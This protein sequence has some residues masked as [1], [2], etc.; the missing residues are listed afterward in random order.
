MASF[1]DRHG[2]EWH[3]EITP[4]SMKRVRELTAVN[5]GTLFNDNMTP[6]ANLVSDPIMFVDVLYV[7]CKP[8]CD[9]LG[10]T[11]EQF[12]G[13]MVGDYLEAAVDAFM[14]GLVD[15]FPKRQSNLLSTLLEK[16]RQY[17]AALAEKAVAQLNQ[18]DVTSIGSAMNLQP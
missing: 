15:F 11:D 8:E 13:A 3:F 6:L 12:G 9:K 14:Q 16:N 5:L 10:V 7:L 17:A 18:L 1:K 2:R 4:F